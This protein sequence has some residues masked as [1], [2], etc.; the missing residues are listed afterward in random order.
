MP[1]KII[2]PFI[3]LAVPWLV[4]SHSSMAGETVEDCHSVRFGELDW[5]DL[6]AAN[7]I[8]EVLLE[9]LG[10]RVTINKEVASVDIMDHM[11]NGSVDV[12]L[13]YWKPS[14]D[15]VVQ[16]YIDK[17]AVQILSAN[18]FDARYTL[19]VP[20][21]VFDQGVTRFEDLKAHKDKFNDRIYG[22]EKDTSGNRLIQDMIDQNA[23]E[24]GGFK[25][26]ATSEFLMLAQIKRRTRSNDWIVF[27]GW[28]PHPMNQH[29][30]IAYLSGGQPYF[31]KNFGNASVYTLVR[32]GVSGRCQ[33]LNRFLQNLK[34][35][36]ATLEWIMD[37]VT[38][39]FVP[40]DR[41]ARLWITQNPEYLSGWL[42]GVTQRSGKAINTSA[43]LK[44][45]E[46]THSM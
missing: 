13:G 9:Q 34:F 24:L 3:L 14:M 10:Y 21:Y 8:S 46:L 30:D 17:Q 39:Q 44:N 45:L 22:L 6:K 41:A 40:A 11:A 12:F 7:A 43:L 25:L 28:Q 36:A 19:A 27:L 23:F 4:C 26:V 2:L 42:E 37:M 35:P 1:I 20:Q 31:G 5:T 38:N 16:P 29:F 32:R 18:M 15:S 33:N